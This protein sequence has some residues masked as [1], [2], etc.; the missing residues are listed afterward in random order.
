MGELNDADDIGLPNV[1]DEMR[2]AN[3]TTQKNRIFLSKLL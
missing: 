1:G 2:F 3:R